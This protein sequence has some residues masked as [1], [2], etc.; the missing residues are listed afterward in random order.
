[1][2][3]IKRNPL[4]TVWMVAATIIGFFVNNSTLG[5]ALGGG[6]V[7]L[8][9]S[10]YLALYLYNGPTGVAALKRLVP[11]LVVGAIVLVLWLS[12]FAIPAF[13]G[14]GVWAGAISMFVV[15]VFARLFR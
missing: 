6:A 13:V 8:V 5:S 15:A 7:A 9:T 12:G 11:A 10:A 2:N 4:A 3:W 1:M 14:M